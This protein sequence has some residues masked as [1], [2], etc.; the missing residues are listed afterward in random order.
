[1]KGPVGHSEFYC[2]PV[3]GVVSAG[4]RLKG[5]SISSCSHWSRALYSSTQAAKPAEARVLTPFLHQATLHS[6]CVIALLWIIVSEWWQVETFD[7]FLSNSVCMHVCVWLHHDFWV[8]PGQE[9]K[10]KSSHLT[11]DSEKTVNK[12]MQTPRYRRNQAGYR[13]KLWMG[14]FFSCGKVPMMQSYHVLSSSRQLGMLLGY[15][16]F[17]VFLF[18]TSRLAWWSTCKTF[19]KRVLGTINVREDH[20]VHLM[21]KDKLKIPWGSCL[22]TDPSSKMSTAWKWSNTNT[23]T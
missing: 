6:S 17:F 18:F 13:R 20:C 19:K 12:T 16:V 21:S 1:M 23:L 14:G 8:I 5:S 2:C 9:I 3:A 7:S 4:S 22:N 15:N 11:I 10:A